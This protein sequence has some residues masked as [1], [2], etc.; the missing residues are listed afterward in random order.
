M[1]GHSNYR[2]NQPRT[3]DVVLKGTGPGEHGPKSSKRWERRV[4]MA[5]GRELRR[6]RAQGSPSPVE[7][8]RK[9]RNAGGEASLGPGVSRTIPPRGP[10][11]EK[12]K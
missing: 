10:T 4:G 5:F 8:Q 2:L 12:R 1:D 3:I 11:K 6:V 7:R 9:E